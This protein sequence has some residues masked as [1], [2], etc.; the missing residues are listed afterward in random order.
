[1]TTCFVSLTLSALY[2]SVV[3]SGACYVHHT[4]CNR[5]GALNLETKLDTARQS[6]LTIILRCLVVRV[7]AFFS[8]LDK[9]VRQHSLIAKPPRGAS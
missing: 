6:A 3:L 4:M 5:W 9:L 2:S 1:M 8:R 7:K